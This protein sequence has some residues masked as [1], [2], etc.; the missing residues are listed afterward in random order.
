[1]VAFLHRCLVFTYY[2]L[3]ALIL[4][5]TFLQVNTVWRVTVY[6]NLDRSGLESQHCQSAVF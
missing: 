2:S 3:C 1:M 4:L 6:L 5:S